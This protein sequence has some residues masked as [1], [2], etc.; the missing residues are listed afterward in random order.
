MST[1]ATF[2]SRCQVGVLSFVS[3]LTLALCCPTDTWAQ[4]MP[5]EG[6]RLSKV[7]YRLFGRELTAVGELTYQGE[8][9]SLRLFDERLSEYYTVYVEYADLLNVSP[10][11]RAEAEGIRRQREQTRARSIV[12]REAEKRRRALI[13]AAEKA[14]AAAKETGRYSRRGRRGARKSPGAVDMPGLRSASAAAGHRVP[15]EPG[16][17]VDALAELEDVLKPYASRIESGQTRITELSKGL[18]EVLAQEKPPRRARVMKGELQDLAARLAKI[19]QYYKRRLKDKTWLHRDV[20]GGELDQKATRERVDMALR[21]ILGMDRKL[22]K[23]EAQLL[24]EEGRL[25]SWPPA[26]VVTEKE[27]I[28]VVP[29]AEETAQARIEEPPAPRDT[30]A[31]T[32]AITRAPTIRAVDEGMDGLGVTR[33]KTRSFLSFSMVFLITISLVLLTLL[34]LGARGVVKEARAKL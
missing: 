8:R 11:S 13:K 19:S 12:E 25:K 24:R 1:P 26:A 32:D 3:S 31:K 22:K 16:N 34:V 10:V 18:E 15:M 9:V 6:G 30:E 33:P 4:V 21:Q 29:T 14:T 17:A 23:F 5:R 7:Q 28:A 20:D 2:R 27:A